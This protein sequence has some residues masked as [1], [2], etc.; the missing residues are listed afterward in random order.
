MISGMTDT[1]DHPTTPTTIVDPPARTRHESSGLYRLLAWVGIIA[2][3]LFI[4]SVVFFS[5]FFLGKHSGGGPGHHFGGGM[6]FMHRG[7][8]PH[9][10]PIGPGPWSGPGGQPGN[11]GQGLPPGPSPQPPT[12]LPAPPPPRP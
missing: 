3:V 5:G 9:G 1:V 7:G 8:P 10:G 4:V 6:H 2:G 12:S 11:A